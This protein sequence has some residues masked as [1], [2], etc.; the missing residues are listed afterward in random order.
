MFLAG[1]K[2][3]D[4]G[5]S[6][7]AGSKDVREGSAD[8]ARN[9]PTLGEVRLQESAVAASQFAEW[10]QGFDHARALRPA[11]ASPGGQ[12]HHCDFA[13]AQGLQAKRSEICTP[14]VQIR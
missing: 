10:M 9:A 5:V 8:L 7:V 3:L 6:Q 4:R 13:L 1:E 11:T 14:S 12:G 2:L